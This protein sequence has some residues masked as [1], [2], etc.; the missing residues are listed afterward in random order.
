LKGREDRPEWFYVWEKLVECRGELPADIPASDLLGLGSAWLRDREGRAEWSYV[1]EALLKERFRSAEMLSLG[2]EWLCRSASLD[3]VSWTFVWERLDEHRFSPPQ[4][5]MKLEEV[6]WSWL[7]RTQNRKRG[8]WD[9]IFETC[10]KRGYHDPQ[11]LQAGAEWAIANGSQ[12]QAYGIAEQLL[13]AS[14]QTLGWEVPAELL[15]LVRTWLRSQHRHRSWTWVWQ[16]LW[17][18]EP[19][20]ETARLVLPW[21]ESGPPA[22][23]VFWAARILAETHRPEMVEVLSAWVLANPDRSSAPVVGQALSAGSRSR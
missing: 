2:W 5:D 18:V 11:F 23:A 20:V 14:R 17:V 4:G 19:T 8:E 6:A 13:L 12:P 22:K 21:F 15:S 16:A 7:K 10:L 3:S 9:K 1:W